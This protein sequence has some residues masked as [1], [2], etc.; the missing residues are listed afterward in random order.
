MIAQN[1]AELLC[2]IFRKTERGI[3]FTI[4]RKNIR[5]R[6]KAARGGRK[7]Y[8]VA[9]V[10]DEQEAADALCECLNRYG[11]EQSVKFE[12]LRYDSGLK[13]LDA[14]K[15][16][17]DLV[18]MD[19]EM[20]DID[21]IKTAE[22]LR[23]I[24]SC[25]GLVFITNLAKY[26]IKGYEYD[27]LD[28]ILKPLSYPV[29]KLKLSRILARIRK[30]NKNIVLSSRSGQNVIPLNSVCYVEVSAHTII[31]H[32]EHNDYTEYGTLKE[33]LKKFP[34]DQFIRC[35]NCYLVNLAHVTGY[36]GSVLE[37]GGY[38]LEI[39]R[40]RKREV[41]AAYNAYRMGEGN[42]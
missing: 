6:K 23:Q 38:Q 4:P 19:I 28:Y 16:A 5:G 14:Y 30:S 31:Y 32:T 7:M 37:V 42:D 10:E 11:E 12:I 27:A 36:N 25:V 17:F 1:K 21:G 34:P 41:I 18:F 26:A 13:F 40:S 22:K 33:A 9:V 29:F 8:K 20:P 24:D 3:D 15:S 2:G 35:N 39:S